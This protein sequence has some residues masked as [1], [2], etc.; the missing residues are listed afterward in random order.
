MKYYHALSV[1]VW[2]GRFLI[3][4]ALHRPRAGI[5]HDTWFIA[6]KYIDIINEAF[7][8]IWYQEF[9]FLISR[10]IFWYQEFHF[11]ISRNNKYLFVSR[12]HF[13]ISINR[14]LDINNYKLFL[15][16][17]KL[18]SFLDIKNSISWYQEI[19]H[20]FLTS[21]NRIPDI[22]KP[23]LDIKKSI[24]WYQELLLFFISTKG[25]LDIKNS[26]SWYQEMLNK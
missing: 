6:Y 14:I 11:L 25:L 3:N 21:K 23:F 5:F 26:I 8:S 9:D 19:I 2:I 20:I 22:K 10:N 24:S 7:F 17:K 12:I 16:I 13:L 15:D 18:N 1:F 4:R